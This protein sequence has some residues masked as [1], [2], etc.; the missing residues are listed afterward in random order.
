MSFP[1]LTFLPVLLALLPVAA[2]VVGAARW[3]RPPPAG[4]SGELR[5][6]INQLLLGLD[7]R[8]P[9]NAASTAQRLAD[10]L[11][12]PLLLPDVELNTARPA[13][14]VSWQILDGGRRMILELHPDGRWNNG[15][16]VTAQDFVR[17]A[18]WTLEG[19]FPHPL[20][21]QLQGSAEYRS[22]EG[23]LDAVGIR[24]LDARRLEVEF[25]QAPGDPA[26]VIASMA[27]MPL[28]PGTAEVLANTAGTPELVSNGAFRLEKY[29]PQE[30]VLRRNPRHRAA[31]GVALETVRLIPTESPK[32]M[33]SLFAA[34]RVDLTVPL[35]DWMG[36]RDAAKPAGVGLVAE[37]SANLSLLHFNLRRA[38]L[39][40]VRVR[41]ALSLALDREQ[42]ARR[43]LGSGAKPAW[44]LTP[45]AQV[46]EAEQTVSEDLA[47]A[48][49]LLAE[50]GF[51]DG[52][53]FPVL[54]VPMVATGE[55]TPLLH[56]CADQWRQRLGI[57]VYVAP[58]PMEEVIARSQAGD[59]DLIHYLWTLTPIMVSAAAGQNMAQLPPGFGDWDQSTVNTLVGEA[60]QLT[61]AARRRKMAEAE[62]ALLEQMPLTPLLSYQ[63][64]V[65]K[66][67][68]VEGWKRDIYGA[69]PFS[70][71][72]LRVAAGDPSS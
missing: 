72:S 10:A 44:S 49:R 35:N 16:P 47:A 6:A 17:S 3:Q 27:F 50:A 7:F 31:A 42:L 66:H 61:G 12:E 51:P 2:I 59:F 39:N 23:R 20:V 65:L 19:G 38:P 45:L 13:A 40:D 32:L 70:E 30:I 48:R 53:G 36:A 71:L 34:G 46:A 52:E 56:F 67:A 33:R 58:L 26:G 8:Q 68:R 18:H 62:R 54:R 9:R 25:A 57:R 22:G 69:H 55:S 4:G 14:A 21:N 11:W 60:W 1:R 28:H 24:A 41:R 43:F 29:S 5:V 63:M 64:F 37:D 15:E